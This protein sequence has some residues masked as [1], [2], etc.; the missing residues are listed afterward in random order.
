MGGGSS[1]P[2][3]QASKDDGFKKNSGELDQTE[4]AHQTQAAIPVTDENKISVDD[5]A[6]DAVDDG[7]DMQEIEIITAEF[8]WNTGQ[9]F[10]ASSR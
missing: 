1:I 10:L 6:K 4:K 5:R 3:K 8:A 2:R 7:A 9:T